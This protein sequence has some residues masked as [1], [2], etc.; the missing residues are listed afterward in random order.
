MSSRQQ[1]TR[2]LIY[3]KRLALKFLTNVRKLTLN[4]RCKI[5]IKLCENYKMSSKARYFLKNLPAKVII[6]NYMLSK[7][8]NIKGLFK[9]NTLSHLVYASRIGITLTMKSPVFY[10]TPYENIFFLVCQLD[11][12]LK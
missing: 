8:Y 1:K 5:K 2:L 4:S 7:K 6:F 12:E 9:G 10:L 11:A 3:V